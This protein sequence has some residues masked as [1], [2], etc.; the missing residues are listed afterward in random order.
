MEPQTLSIYA[1]IVVGAAGIGLGVCSSSFTFDSTRLIRPLAYLVILCLCGVA[2]RRIGYP[3][4]GGFSEALAQLS[5]L[6]CTAAWCT[7]LLAATSLPFADGTLTKA[8]AIVFF[9]FDWRSLLPFIATHD[10]VVTGLS[11]V[12]ASLSWQ[13]TLILLALFT[14]GQPSRSWAFILA[15]GLTLAACTAI[16]PFVP[17]LGTYLHYG[18][19][20][21]DVPGVHVAAAWRH[22]ELLLPVRQGSVRSISPD[23][24]YGIV[25]FPSFHA[26]GAVLLGWAGWTLGLLRWPF[27]LLNVMMFGSAL[28]IGGHY[29]IDLAAGGA[30]AAGAVLVS[31]RVTKRLGQPLPATGVNDAYSTQSRPM[32]R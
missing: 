2:L 20:P 23:T 29:L 19:A 24:L 11:Y 8:D 6:S 17:A 9:G 12:Y 14:A 10:R 18:I 25:T 30:V 3:R 13:P 26:A 4:F 15:W 7:T 28:V 5:A 22:I 31:A 1:L 27:V 21:S 16:F 32:S